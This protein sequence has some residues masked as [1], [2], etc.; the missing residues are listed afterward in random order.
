MRIVASWLAAS[1]VL[2]VSIAFLQSPRPAQ[3]DPRAGRAAQAEERDQGPG[4]RAD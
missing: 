3:A 2:V 4:G 1:A